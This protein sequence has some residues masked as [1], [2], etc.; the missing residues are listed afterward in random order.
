MYKTTDTGNTWQA[1]M[2]TSA[3]GIYFKNQNTGWLDAEQS[4]Y[5]TDNAGETWQKLGKTFSDPRYPINT[6]QFTDDTHGWMCSYM[7]LN[8]TTDGGSTWTA[9]DFVS[10]A[11]DFHFFNNNLGYYCT[12]DTIFKTSDGGVTWSPNCII[13]GARLA[14]VSFLDEHTGWACGTDG[15]FLR[16]K[17]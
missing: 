5:K 7:Y 6:L 15:T 17:N 4:I 16:L 9:H 8:K 2:T 1:K 13:P 10:W 11:I 12:T 3:N 14:E